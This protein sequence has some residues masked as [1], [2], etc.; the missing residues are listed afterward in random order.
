MTAAGTRQVALVTG[1]AGALAQRVGGD[2]ARRGYQVVGVDYRP[3]AAP[4]DFA[5]EVYRANYNKTKIEDIFR[6]H[7]PTLVLHLG[8]VGNLKERMAK[9]FDLNVIGSRKV[10]D[11]CL[12][13]GT[14]RLVVLSTFHIYGA[15]PH[16]HIPIL[17]DEP[18][19]AGPD[20]PQIA[21]AIQLDNQALL[22]IYRHPQVET[23]LLRPTNVVGTDLG[24]AMSKFLRQLTVPTVLGFN[25]MTQ[26]IHADDL[27]A[28]VVA[29]AL[30]QAVGVFNLAGQGSMP[31]KT[32]LVIAGCRQVPVP[33]S[34]AF[35]L[36][37]GALLARPLFRTFPP[38]LINFF[39]YPCI[40]SDEAFRA[41]FDWQPT[42][43]QEEAIRKTVAGA[44][45]D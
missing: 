16:N 6:R 7:Q 10:M 44:R 5:T 18:L 42:V 39:K 17:E 35:T 37:R 32:A 23:V 8:R 40:I 4:L 31:W 33:S 22:W 30:G 12:R 13:Y 21:D 36:L 41:A 28:A 2:L 20:F 9:R 43:G 24:N 15:H 45:D 29:A 3:L 34:L 38:Y 26:F 25:P 14:R 27:A 1:I 11:Q 19:R